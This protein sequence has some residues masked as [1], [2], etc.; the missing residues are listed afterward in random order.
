[1]DWLAGDWKRLNEFGKKEG[2]I[3]SYHVFSVSSPRAGDPDL[4]LAVEAKDYYSTAQQ[5]EQQKRLEAFLKSDTR[6]LGKEYGERLS[7]RKDI[8][9]MEMQELVLK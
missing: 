6:Q 2:Y 3:V 7:M 8:G 5:R 4:I 9:G 1:M